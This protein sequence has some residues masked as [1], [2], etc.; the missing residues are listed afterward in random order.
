MAARLLKKLVPVC[1][2]W[3]VSFDVLVEADFAGPGSMDFVSGDR[4]G[5]AVA[6]P[7]SN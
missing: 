7:N 4:D 5:F 1:R 2:F 3:R 6:A